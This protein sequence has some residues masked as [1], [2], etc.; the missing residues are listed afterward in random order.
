MMNRPSEKRLCTS[1]NVPKWL[2]LSCI[3]LFSYKS[4][5][6]SAINFFNHTEIS[7]ALTY[8]NQR[9]NK[10]FEQSGRHEQNSRADIEILF[11]PNEHHSFVA[12]LRMSNGNGIETGATSS[13]NAVVPGDENDFNKPVLLQGFYRY[14]NEIGLVLA[15]G[16][17]DPYAFF[18]GNNYADDET[19]TFI[20]LSFIHNPLLDVGGDLNPGT[21]GGTPGMYAQKT[22]DLMNHSFALSFGIFGSGYGADLKGSV[23]NRITLSQIEWEHSKATDEYGHYRV[24]FW[25]R[26]QGVD[27]DGTSE[28]PRATGWGIS[29][30][31]SVTKH[32]GI[33][34]RYG[35]SA[36]DL[37]TVGIDTALTSGISLTGGLWGRVDDQI[38]IAYG[39]INMHTSGDETLYEIYYRATLND[40][41]SI[42]PSWQQIELVDGTAVEIVTLR[43]SLTF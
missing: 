31:Q 8:A 42:T 26:N 32:F 38:G 36:D 33:F 37:K 9:S 29:L 17:M 12:H 30:D 4:Y 16:Q 27:V 6:A 19:S 5:D 24:Y 22:Y 7:G 3:A 13:V 20:N 41:L 15:L 34:S 10:T 39:D 18:D 23:K 28:M 11:E 25:D 21:Y 1:L 43:A 14:T 2:I 35:V 40:S